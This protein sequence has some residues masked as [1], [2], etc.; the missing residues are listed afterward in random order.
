M[1]IV[2]GSRFP[3]LFRLLCEGSVPSVPKNLGLGVSGS[4]RVQGL[5]KP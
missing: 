2:Q 5:L 1:G 4:I 3:K